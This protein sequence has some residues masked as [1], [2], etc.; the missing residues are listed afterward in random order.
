MEYS[1]YLECQLSGCYDRQTP[2]SD[3]PQSFEG[4]D[5]IRDERCPVCDCHDYIALG[6]LGNLEYRRCRACGCDYSLEVR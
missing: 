4:S 6:F 1:A 2:M 3:D 5:E